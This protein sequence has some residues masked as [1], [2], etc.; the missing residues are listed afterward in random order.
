MKFSRNIILLILFAASSLVA[1]NYGGT[2]QTNGGNPG[3]VQGTNNPPILPSVPSNPP[4]VSE[5]AGSE[6]PAVVI[7]AQ[8][9]VLNDQQK[10]L[11]SQKLQEI[12]GVIVITNRIRVVG[13]ISE[14]AGAA[15]TNRTFDR[16]PTRTNRRPPTTPKSF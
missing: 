6:K 10:R 2:N 4:Q 11:I 7:T 9:T 13:E 1:Q 8:G 16:T 14:A 12:P 15:R 5:A 3:V